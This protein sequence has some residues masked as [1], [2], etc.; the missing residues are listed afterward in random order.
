MGGGGVASAISDCLRIRSADYS[1]GL[2]ECALGP[3]RF[4]ITQPFLMNLSI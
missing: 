1:V 2:C 3:R 4:A